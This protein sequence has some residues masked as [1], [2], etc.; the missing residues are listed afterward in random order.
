[1]VGALSSR[2]SE[3]KPALA[4]VTETLA[5]D[6]RRISE[7]ANSITPAD[8]AAVAESCKNHA[9]GNRP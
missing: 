4:R 8:L 5:E 3:L 6:L 9:Q 2:E 1:M 7:V